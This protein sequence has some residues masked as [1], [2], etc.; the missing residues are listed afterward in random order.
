M[1]VKAI[2]ENF[3]HIVTTQYFDFNGRTAREPFWYYI[4]AY[5]VLIVAASILETVLFGNPLMYSYGYHPR[6]LTA[7][8]SLALL[9]PNLG[10]T[11]RRLHDIDRSA[12]WM[13]VGLIPFAGWLVM[14][15]W[16]VQPGT[17]GSNQFGSDPK[18][19]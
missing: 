13:L 11:A 1:D 2:V 10:I 12:W 14:I 19:V 8:L 5:V 18:A 17:S 15:Y 16:C 4:L 9:L 7:L 3:R 6:P